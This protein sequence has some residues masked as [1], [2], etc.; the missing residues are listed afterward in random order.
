ME[1][2][3][4]A[5]IMAWPETVCKRPG[6]WYENLMHRTKFSKQG[7]YKVGHAAVT[8]I[9]GKSGACLYFDFGRYHAPYGY[10][11]ARDVETDLELKI[12][13]QISFE[14]NRPTNLS[15]LYHELQSREA[16]HGDG[17]LEVGLVPID[18]E[19]AFLQAKKIQ[20]NDFVNYGPFT[21]YG[22]N[23]S[24]FVREVVNAGHRSIGMKVAFKSCYALTPTPRWLVNVTKTFNPQLQMWN[25]ELENDTFKVVNNA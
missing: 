9:N 22:T 16:C 21:P 20:Q 4:F 3:S 6:G 15:Q 8:L 19:K 13:T 7:Y 23:C 1:N 11:R 24:R 17:R 18:F 25:T 2:Q 14:S 12:T 5:L 10:G